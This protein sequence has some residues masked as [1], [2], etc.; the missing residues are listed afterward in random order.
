VALFIQQ[1]ID[2]LKGL[3]K[4]QRKFLTA[5][6]TAILV[7]QPRINFSSL[8]RHS[9]LEE[10]TFRRHF[11]RQVDFVA[12]NESIMAQAQSRIVAFAMDASFI[13]KSGDHTFGLDKFWN[14]GAGKA[15]KGLEAS[16]ISLLDA[17]SNASWALSVKQTEPPLAV[18]EEAQEKLT[19]TDFYAAQLAQVAPTL[20]KYTRVGVCSGFYAKRKFVAKT[21]ALGFTMI[22]RLRQDANLKHLHQGPQ[23]GRGR[24][25]KFAG[26][27][28]FSDLSRFQAET[29][30]TPQGALQ[31]HSGVVWSV[32]LQRA[33]K[34]VVV[35]FKSK[36]VQLF[37]TDTKL[38][39]GEIYQLYRRRFS[40]EF[41]IRDAKQ[42][43]GLSDCQAR[44]QAALEFH[45][46]A[47]FTSVNLA[48]AMSHSTESAA[49]KQPFSMKS[50]KQ[51]FFNEH[52]LRLFIVKSGLAQ[53]LIKY[54]E[55]LLSCNYLASEKVMSL[56]WKTLTNS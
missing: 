24:P 10:K 46:Q 5:L 33:I 30:V 54:E 41:L 22:S 23:K 11:R 17:R 13:R 44:D 20:L 35:G 27:V 12:V 48:R 14:G 42:S 18:T 8:A 9:D 50:L 40:L 51:Q 53:S 37:A 47:S 25:R 34:L 3:H 31:L 26:K 32:S 1:I 4:P 43:G 56:C 39:A 52:L 28:D 36:S 55:T 16:V 38:A 7:C 21:V 2:G 29:V 45:W 19:R 49:E 6:F 15:Q